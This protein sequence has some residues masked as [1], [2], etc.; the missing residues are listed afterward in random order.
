[1][2]P[3]PV[4]RAEAWPEPPLTQLKVRGAMHRGCRAARG[5]ARRAK[6]P[7]H[8]RH[9][10]PWTVGMMPQPPQKGPGPRPPQPVPSKFNM[11]SVDKYRP[12][13]TSIN[14]WLLEAAGQLTIMEVFGFLLE[15]QT[16]HSSAEIAGWRNRALLDGNTRPG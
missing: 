5:G 9:T 10:L 15:T 11:S 13:E 7:A 14:E 3:G 8:P 4:E 2:Q 12:G 16:A 1:M 6:R